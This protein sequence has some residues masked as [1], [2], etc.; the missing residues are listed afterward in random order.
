MEQ[1]L[2]YHI[3]RKAG[4]KTLCVFYAIYIARLPQKSLY[5]I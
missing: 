5:F 3:F 1:F 2:S 4:T